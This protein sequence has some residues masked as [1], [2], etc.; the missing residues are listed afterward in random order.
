MHLFI[1]LTAHSLRYMAHDMIQRGTTLTG[2]IDASV[3]IV[4]VTVVAIVVII[5]LLS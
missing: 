1:T 2:C 5:V 4:L 3:H